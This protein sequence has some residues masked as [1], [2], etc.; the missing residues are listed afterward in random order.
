MPLQVSLGSDRLRQWLLT[1]LSKEP[2]SRR[3]PVNNTLSSHLLM[4]AFLLALGAVACG[5]DDPAVESDPGE[6]SA[7]GPI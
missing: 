7:P 1:R 5:S 3:C 6:L 4:V 2:V